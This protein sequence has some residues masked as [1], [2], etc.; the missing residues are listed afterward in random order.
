M[1]NIKNFWKLVSKAYGLNT[2][3][4]NIFREIYE[5]RDGLSYEQILNK[6]GYVSKSRVQS[7]CSLLRKKLL[8][9]TI[10]SFDKGKI[11]SLNLNHKFK[12]YLTH[13]VEDN[14]KNNLIAIEEGYR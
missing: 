1:H 14:Y 3:E 7:S 10:D 11:F 13:Y 12:K 4:C 5:S 6:T 2:H 9:V 8:I